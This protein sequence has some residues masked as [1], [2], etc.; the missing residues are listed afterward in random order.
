MIIRWPDIGQPIDYTARMRPNRAVLN[1]ART[2][3]KKFFTRGLGAGLEVTRL[4]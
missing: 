1:H 4:S 2:T 3:G